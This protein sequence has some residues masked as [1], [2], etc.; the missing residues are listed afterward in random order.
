[1]NLDFRKE[2]Y[3]FQVRT[4]ALIFN[5]SKDKILLFN[6]EDKDYYLLPGGR[7]EE[8]ENSLEAI[9]RE[10][11]EELNWKIDNFEFLSL[12]EELVGKNHQINII[13][14]VAIDKDI[15]IESFKGIEGEWINFK[16]INISDINKYTI[17]PS[18]IKEIVKNTNKKY[19]SIED[20]DRAI[21]ILE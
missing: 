2:K 21:N 12:S 13:Y 10:I 15:D 20:V 7:V 5:N 9:K 8:K 16:W 11:K 1:M 14:K 17:Y 19:H 4:S 3:R 18:S 6:V